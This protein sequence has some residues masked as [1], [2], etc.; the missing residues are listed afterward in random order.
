LSFG[1]KRLPVREGQS[2]GD[3]VRD[4]EAAALIQQAAEDI[5][6]GK[7]TREAAH[8]MTEQTG[9]RWKSV[10]VSR[11]FRQPSMLGYRAVGGDVYR[12][13]SG[14]PIQFTEPILTPGMVARA[15]R[16]LRSRY[17]GPTQT[18]VRKGASLLSRLVTC[19]CGRNINH[20][21]QF[22]RRQPNKKAIRYYYCKDCETTPKNRIRA[23]VLEDYV[24][25][26]AL[27]YLAKLEPGSAIMDEVGKRWLHRYSP[28]QLSRREGLE[29]EAD[30]VRG[31]LS[32]LRRDYYEQKRIPA[33]EFTSM[34]ANLNRRLTGLE[35]EAKDLPEAAPDLGVLLDLRS[36]DRGDGSDLVGPDSAWGALEH[37]KRREILY[38]LV[39]SFTLGLPVDGW[40]L[41]S[42]VDITLATESNVA[43]LPRRLPKKDRA[44]LAEAV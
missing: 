5:V 26:K 24:V 42:R 2:S 21:T 12:D 18:K 13:E 16:V 38:T 44:V 28:D 17:V 22:N 27:S 14:E 8:W 41:A 39:E 19:H 29:D 36:A 31:Q 1:L 9:V 34:E 4:D 6:A 35:D 10:R 11:M 3:V 25:T 7:T 23:E 30:G 40:T 37:H 15:D 20:T 32:T 43:S 33:D